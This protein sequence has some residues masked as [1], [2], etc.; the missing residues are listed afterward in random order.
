MKG[1]SIWQ[2]S[3]SIET[4][5][6]QLR[7]HYE[8][9]DT[10]ELLEYTR[11]DLTDEARVILEDVLRKR[12][13]APD[14]AAQA[15]TQADIRETSATDEQALLA[16][17][18]SRVVAFAIDTVGVALVLGVVLLPLRTIS[19]DAYKTVFNVIWFA[20]FLLRDSIPGQSAGK[21]ALKIR[22]TQLDSNRACKWPQSLLRYAWHLLFGI[23]ALFA[24]GCRRMRIGDMVAGTKVIRTD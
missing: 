13:I 12:N 11:K 3:K 9:L 21:R 15:R 4:G 1:D 23:D 10:E 19:E 8:R 7:D 16:P 17:P 14:V 20:Y 6:G 22:V 5:M 18:G 2:Y 24:L